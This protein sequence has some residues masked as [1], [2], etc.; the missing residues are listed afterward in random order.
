[1]KDFVD[2]ALGSLKS[3]DLIR[4]MRIGPREHD[5]VHLAATCDQVGVKRFVTRQPASATGAAEAV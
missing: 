3:D 4:G 5:H 2:L 1:V